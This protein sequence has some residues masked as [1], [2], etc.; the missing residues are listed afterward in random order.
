V[1]AYVVVAGWCPGARR[2]A[3]EVATDSAGLGIA[4][5][6]GAGTG[7]RAA[8]GRLGR[9]FRFL[10]YVGLKQ[11]AERLVAPRAGGGGKRAGRSRRPSA[12]GSHYPRFTPD[13]RRTTPGP[14]PAIFRVGFETA[15]TISKNASV[16]GS[17]AR[18]FGLPRA[19]CLS[20]S[21]TSVRVEFDL[22]S[23]PEHILFSFLH[24][25]P[26]AAVGR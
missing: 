20:R 23:D 5:T 25:A 7:T 14:S 17:F 6:R 19:L 3:V 2:T 4:L 21:R 15:F 9:L 16:S 26:F 8:G 22:L 24:S 10:G 1:P 18:V 13:R 12:G 11:G